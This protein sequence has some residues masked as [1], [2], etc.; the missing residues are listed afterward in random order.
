MPP[1]KA[2]TDLAARATAWVEAHADA[3]LRSARRRVATDHEAK[4]LVQE[5]LLA[6]WRIR[7]RDPRA[8]EPDAPILHGILRNKV[9]DHYRRVFRERGAPATAVTD[10]PAD[11]DDAGHWDDARSPKRWRE[12]SVEDERGRLELRESL[13]GCLE[14]LPVAQAR[15]FLLREADGMDTAELLRI[16]GLSETNLFVLL[17]RARLALRACLEKNHF[18]K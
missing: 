13:S 4:D 15:V 9:A 3:L 7:M 6:A 2:A 18:L 5:T 10:A 11:F 12:P 8:P 14:K 1:D 16:T 17:H